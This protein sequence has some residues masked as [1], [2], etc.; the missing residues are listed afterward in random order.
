MIG[1]LS[2][3][4]GLADLDLDGSGSPA[5]ASQLSALGISTDEQSQ[6]ALLYPPGQSVWRV[7]ITHFS[8]ED[9]NWPDSPPPDVEPPDEPEPDTDEPEEN[10]C[11][12]IGSIIEIQNQILREQIGIVGAPFSLNYSSE[13]VAGRNA[14]NRLTIPLSGA[15]IPASLKRIELE[16]TVAGDYRPH[17]THLGRRLTHCL[18]AD[19]D[20]PRTRRASA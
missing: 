11:D 10:P 3:T 18:P 17:A 20:A 6:L 15:T 14:H 7:P 1:I 12:G 2:V 8:P 5:S 9:Y 4:G 13:R 16:I 19:S